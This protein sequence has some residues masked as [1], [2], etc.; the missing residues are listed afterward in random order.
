MSVWYRENDLTYVTE[1]SEFS[2]NPVHP[3]TGETITADEFRRCLSPNVVH[4]EI[5]WW[6]GQLDNGAYVLIYNT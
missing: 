2:R 6:Y 5:R 1:M 3:E 4:E